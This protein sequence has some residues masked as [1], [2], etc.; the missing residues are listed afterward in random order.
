MAHSLLWHTLK[1]QSCLIGNVL[2][3]ANAH[4]MSPIT[5]SISRKGIRSTMAFA[6]LWHSLDYGIRP[7]MAVARLWHS[8]D[9]FSTFRPNNFIIVYS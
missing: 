3:P 1:P 5:G 2:D 8:L 4:M 9:M 6:Q 7:T